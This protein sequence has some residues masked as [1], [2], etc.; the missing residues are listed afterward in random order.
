MPLADIAQAWLAFAPN[1]LA[2]HAI[3]HQPYELNYFK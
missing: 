2:S 3:Y 1:K